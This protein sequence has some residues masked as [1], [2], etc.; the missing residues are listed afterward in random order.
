MKA[1]FLT[2]PLLFL[3][4]Q[5]LFSAESV[6]FRGKR[7]N[8]SQEDQIRQPNEDIEQM[9]QKD[10]TQKERSKNS[11]SAG[12]GDYK[13]KERTEPDNALIGEI[14]QMLEILIDLLP[15][16]FE[17][18]HL[19]DISGVD[20]EREE[21]SK[22]G[23]KSFKTFNDFV[24]SKFQPLRPN[25]QN[26]QSGDEKQPNIHSFIVRSK[27]ADIK[28]ERVK[29]DKDGKAENKLFQLKKKGFPSQGEKK[30]V[31]ENQDFDQMPNQAIIGKGGFSNLKEDN[32]G[33]REELMMP[34]KPKM[35]DRAMFLSPQ[36]LA[37]KKAFP[38]ISTAFGIMY[39]SPSSEGKDRLLDKTRDSDEPNSL[40]DRK[41]DADEAVFGSGKTKPFPEIQSVLAA[42]YPSVS[43]DDNDRLDIGLP[44]TKEDKIDEIPALV[45]SKEEDAVQNGI[46]NI[47]HE[48]LEL[49]EKRS[50]AIIDPI[51]ES[52][53]ESFAAINQKSLLRDLRRLL[54]EIP[55]H[56]TISS[57]D[58][59]KRANSRGSSPRLLESLAILRSL[60]STGP[61]KVEDDI[62]VDGLFNAAISRN[63]FVEP[64]LKRIS[65]GH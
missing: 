22:E 49:D 47:E 4:F 65:Q 40:A 39:Q 42:K 3:L 60:R 64:H 36:R 17:D 11:V 6:N 44:P 35:L 28:S 19:S 37:G 21:N 27:S 13:R 31:E 62:S 15:F 10:D 14:F 58:A 29:S 63:K 20:Q 50:F 43:A 55:A 12:G 33:E 16:K 51:L 2:V 9:V 54:L 18:Q 52:L 53:R 5:S 23:D 41:E 8:R 25:R 38:E 30:S 1:L 45:F 48:L 59:E 46:E 61:R 32:E 34:R 24:K 7:I 57:V 56:Q 26:K